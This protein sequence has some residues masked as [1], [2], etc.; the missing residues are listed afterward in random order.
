MLATGRVLL[1]RDGTLAALRAEAAAIL[2][3]GPRPEPQYLALARYTAVDTL[4]NARDTI[5]DDPEM[6]AALLANTV[7]QAI[8]CRFW[9]ARRWQPPP[10]EVLRA[11]ED[12]DGGLGALAR[13]FH[14]ATLLTDRVAV[15]QE[16]VGRTCGASRFFEWETELEAVR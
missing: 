13:R 2:E 5:D 4:D 6:C 1:D 9:D 8:A 7:C 15:T 11:L 10:K 12:L 3:A 16:I 14:R